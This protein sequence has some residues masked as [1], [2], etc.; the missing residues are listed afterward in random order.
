MRRPWKLREICC[1][2]ET[3]PFF[4]ETWELADQARQQ[5][6]AP[7]PW[8]NSERWKHDRVGIIESVEASDD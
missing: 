1:G 6:I 7:R 2:I 5:W 3:Q 4:F 8:D